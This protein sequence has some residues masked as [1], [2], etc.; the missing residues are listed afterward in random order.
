V[1]TRVGDYVKQHHLA[2]LCLFF[3]VGGG[4]AWALELNSVRSE[5]IVNRQ[6]KSNDLSDK[7]QPQ[8]AL[9]KEDGSIVDQS[10]G[11][12]VDGEDQGS[13]V[14]DFGRNV[15]GRALIATPTYQGSPDI[16]TAHVS[17][18]G[19]DS[20]LL[21]AGCDSLADGSD[22]SGDHVLVF[23]QI[24]SGSGGDPASFYVAALPR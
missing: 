4:T 16:A 3:V 17:P 22:S 13:Y 24:T 2:L 7:T 10:G 19:D 1:V 20:D 14:I 11:I 5:H 6:V 12:S 8:W 21:Q 23:T 9:V 15:A 18:C